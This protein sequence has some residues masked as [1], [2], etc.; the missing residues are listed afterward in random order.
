MSNTKKDEVTLTTRMSRAYQITVPS[1][2]RKRL[3][4]EPGDPVEIGVRKGEVILRRAATREEKIKWALAELERLKI[5]REKAMT[6]EQKRFAERSRGWTIRQF[7]EYCDGLP[8][9]KEYIKEKYG[10]KVA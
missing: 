2:V 5:E 6:P 8:E 4:L 10:V 9:A 3:G 7:H 1:V